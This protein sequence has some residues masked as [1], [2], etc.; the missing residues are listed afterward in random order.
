MLISLSHT[1][2]STLMMRYCCVY[3]QRFGPPDQQYYYMNSDDPHPGDS[4]LTQGPESDDIK[5]NDWTF[6]QVSSTEDIRLTRGCDFFSGNADRAALRKRGTKNKSDLDLKVSF[7]K[8]WMWRITIITIQSNTMI[9]I[10]IHAYIH[11]YT[12]NLICTGI[13]C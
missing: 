10:N 12:I 8:H 4:Q 9:S 13:S 5:G 7:T 6:G 2:T 1:H 3:L 11:N